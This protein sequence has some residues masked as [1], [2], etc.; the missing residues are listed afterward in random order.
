MRQSHAV[1]RYSQQSVDL[2]SQ[3]DADGASAVFYRGLGVDVNPTDGGLQDVDDFLDGV[4]SE[5]GQKH[6]LVMLDA[7]RA[8][9]SHVCT[10]FMGAFPM[11]RRW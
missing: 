6:L 10:T 3:L 7:Y 9:L 5:V 11:E 4:V 2:R 1:S 8:S